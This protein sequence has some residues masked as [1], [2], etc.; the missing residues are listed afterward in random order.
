VRQEQSPRNDSKSLVPSLTRWTLHTAS[1]GSTSITEKDA[2]PSSQTSD[3]MPFISITR[4][5]VLPPKPTSL[6]G[7][8]SFTPSLQS[9]AS[10]SVYSDTSIAESSPAPGTFDGGPS[11]RQHGSNSDSIQILTSSEVSHIITP[12]PLMTGTPILS[13]DSSLYTLPSASSSAIIVNSASRDT[14]PSVASSNQTSSTRSGSRSTWYQTSS[15]SS[16]A[17]IPLLP[18]VVTTDVAL[19]VTTAPYVS[20]SAQSS[21]DVSSP[22]PSPVSNLINAT[23]FGSSYVAVSGTGALDIPISSVTSSVVPPGN[24]YTTPLYIP[25]TSSS[26]SHWSPPPT[27]NTSLST[28]AFSASGSIVSIFY[29]AVQSADTSVVVKPS[30]GTNSQRASIAT[31]ATIV[32]TTI[33]VNST[34]SIAHHSP[35]RTG[36][37]YRVWSTTSTVKAVLPTLSFH[38]TA[39]STRL[40]P[41]LGETGLGAS[42]TTVAPIWSNSTISGLVVNLTAAHV[43]TVLADD[44]VSTTS[45]DASPTSTLAASSSEDRVIRTIT[46]VFSPSSSASD[47]AAA[48]PPPSPPLTP[49][50]TA[51]AAVAGTAGLLIAV[52]AAMYVARRYRSKSLRRTSSGSIYPKVAYLYDPPAGGNDSCADIEGTYTSGEG[53][54]MPLDQRNTHQDDASAPPMRFSDPGNPFRDP[55]NCF[56]DSNGY[57]N[58]SAQRPAN[59]ITSFSDTTKGYKPASQ[60]SPTAADFT[61]AQSL[62]DS[63]WP[64]S[65]LS[66]IPD[67]KPE[68]ASRYSLLSEITSMAYNADG[69]PNTL[70]HHR[71]SHFD[72]RSNPSLPNVRETTYTDSCRD[73]FEH[74]LLLEVD[75]RTGTPDSVTVFASPATYERPY[76]S[77]V[78]TKAYSKNPWASSMPN[79]TQ[80]PHRFQPDRELRVNNPISSDATGVLPER[81]SPLYEVPLSPTTHVSVSHTALR[82]PSVSISQ[83]TRALYRG[84]DDIKRSSIER[85]VPSMPDFSVLREFPSPPPRKKTS[86]P[87]FRSRESVPLG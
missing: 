86:L 31:L 1:I 37:E 35:S 49:S 39:L 84:W 82:N 32:L 5:S 51:G 4:T 70:R 68:M 11:T 44:F 38:G 14:L 20:T 79:L 75:T 55:D 80:V 13:T 40:A 85:V 16:S 50:Q 41:S 58:N 52:V 67:G 21:Q 87:Y 74:D 73:P 18:S 9:R 81:F 66:T 61:A 53:P 42:Y 57:N 25:T 24:S 45:S 33:S 60:E 46:T 56:E 10:S 7:T 3:S 19:A 48:S 63:T 47:S 26:S 36:S 8:T 34:S 64:S 72:L 83:P 27:S 69:Y 77:L 30:M 28:N 54:D 23:S 17:S 29:T 65:M 59:T 62:R 6:P 78:P 12:S 2:I 22:L 15:A 43:S 71:S 76:R